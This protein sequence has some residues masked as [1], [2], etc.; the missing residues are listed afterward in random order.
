MCILFFAINKH[1]DYPVIICANRDEF[2]HRPTQKMHLWPQANILAGKDLQAGG[3]WLGLDNAG[4][5]SALTNYRQAD[6]LDRQKKSRGDLVLNA[7]CAQQSHL[8]DQQF[9][10]HL[11]TAAKEYNG[12]NLIFGQLSKLYCFDSINQ[13]L[14]TIDHGFHSICNGAL[15]DIWPKM[16]RGQ[17]QLEQIIGQAKPLDINQ[18]FTVMT[19]QTQAPFEQLPNTGISQKLEQLLSSIFII[20]P[21]YGTR[22]TTIITVTKNAEAVVYERNYLPS[23]AVA[24]QQTFNLP[25][26][27]VST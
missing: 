21:E 11:T 4:N 20:S 7:L 6:K 14:I 22:S 5:F 24:E 16:A 25:S 17:Q 2:H 19:D 15:D 27:F 10:E 9:A 8:P 23:G 12:F 13:K 3:T 1:P 18:L 26:L